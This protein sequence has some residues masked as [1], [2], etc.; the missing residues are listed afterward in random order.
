MNQDRESKHCSEIK[1]TVAMTTFNGSKHIEEQI[2]SILHQT[3]ENIEILIQDDCSTDNTFEILK[4]YTEIDG[5]VSLF[6][7]KKRLGID[8]NFFDLFKKSTSNYI[9]ISD[10]DDIWALNKIE[11]LL[12]QIGDYSLIY[13]DSKLIDSNGKSMNTTLLKEIEQKPKSGKYLCNLLTENTISGHSCMFKSNILSYIHKLQKEN[14][15]SDFFYDKI[16]ATVASFQSGVKY[17][18][19]ALTLH[20]IHQFNNCN[21]LT[22]QS[23]AEDCIKKRNY[24]SHKQSFFE[25]KI[26]R[27]KKKTE[28]AKQHRM[29]AKNLFDSLTDKNENPFTQ[30]QSNKNSFERKFFDFA[31]YNALKNK[32]IPKEVSKRLSFG[33]YYYLLLRIL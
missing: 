24:R 25:R 19:K 2:H 27:V 16:I 11:I 10:Q 14:I 4:R 30:S 17:Y 12:K 28:I 31:L 13:T 23:M 7:N 20:R 5:R 26:M 18:D 15:N 22:K 21:K 9:A 29:F 33:K 32:G 1:V 6:Q 3:H 8:L